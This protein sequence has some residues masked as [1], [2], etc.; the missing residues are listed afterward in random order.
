MPA[1]QCMHR[2]LQGGIIEDGSW[3]ISLDRLQLQHQ[4]QP[5][6]R[7]PAATGST[8]GGP[9]H[10]SVA[11][12]RA[13]RRG[14]I[15]MG[16]VGRDRQDQEG[17]QHLSADVQPNRSSSASGRPAQASEHAASSSGSNGVASAPQGDRPAYSQPNGPVT[18]GGGPPV[19]RGF[20]RGRGRRGQSGRGG[21]GQARV[22]RAP[23]HRLRVGN[24]SKQCSAS[25]RGW[26][27]LRPACQRNF[28]LRRQAKYQAR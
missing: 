17:P 15:K 22:A 12:L 13:P 16:S 20:G 18:S 14:S 10:R 7:P 26:R 2:P 9:A 23:R 4:A 27:Q 21:G 8:R 19:D 6:R 1:L 25:G 11:Q 5:Q 24:S 3:G 28:V